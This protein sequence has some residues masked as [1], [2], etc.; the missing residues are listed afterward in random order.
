LGV[1]Q[2]DLD[3]VEMDEGLFF[4]NVIVVNK[5]DNFSWEIINVYGLVRNEKKG[6]FLQELYQ[7]LM[8]CEVPVVVCGDFNMIKY[9]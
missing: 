6:I 3:V 5:Q 9:G 7:K 2:G 1:K 8:R 4:S